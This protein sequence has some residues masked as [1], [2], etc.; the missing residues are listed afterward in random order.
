MYFGKSVHEQCSHLSDYRRGV[1]AQ[2]WGDHGCLYKLGCLGMDTGCDI[3]RR[4]WLAGQQLHRLR[5]RLHRLHRKTVPDY[6]KRGIYK[7][8]TASLETSSA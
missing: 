1:F 3:P 6:G 7:H 8:L 2:K 4:K 5:F